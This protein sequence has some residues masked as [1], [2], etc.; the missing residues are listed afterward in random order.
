MLESITFAER[1]GVS[2][3]VCRTRPETRAPKHETRHTTLTQIIFFM[4]FPDNCKY[5]KDHEWIRMESGSMAYIGI[6]DFA[7]GELGELVY[8]DVNTVGRELKAN[9]IF[10]TVEAVKTTSDLYMPVEA[11]VM[12]LNFELDTHPNYINE[13]PYGKGWI[14]KVDVIDT[15]AVDMLLDAAAY[16]EFVGQKE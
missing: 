13:D 3:V 9:E 6:T 5:T 8:V 10:G 2:C 14:I 7:Q 12:G 15:L 16:K 4:T 1:V 11:R